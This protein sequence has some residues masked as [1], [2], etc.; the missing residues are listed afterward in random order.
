MNFIIILRSTTGSRIL[1][2]GFRPKIL[3]FHAVYI[4]RP[5]HER[6]F[7]RLN[8]TW[9]KCKAYHCAFF[10]TPLLRPLPYILLCNYLIQHQYMFFYYGN[11]SE[12]CIDESPRFQNRI[13]SIPFHLRLSFYLSHVLSCVI[14]MTGKVTS[15]FNLQ[16]FICCRLGTSHTKKAVKMSYVFPTWV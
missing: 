5:C 3:Y 16:Q 7:D 10:C 4:Y 11:V 8:K 2:Q 6:Y 14:N 1:I 9:W 15:H 13:S 12:T